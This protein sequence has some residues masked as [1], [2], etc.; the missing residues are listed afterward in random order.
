MHFI[1]STTKQSNIANLGDRR[2]QQPKDYSSRTAICPCVLYLHTWMINI[3]V[4]VHPE[5]VL[6]G[7]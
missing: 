1:L 7:L 3:D 2:E 5:S 6:P 4:K